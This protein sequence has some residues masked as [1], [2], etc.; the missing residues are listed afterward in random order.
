MMD[1]KSNNKNTYMEPNVCSHRLQVTGTHRVQ[2]E[3]FTYDY[4][5]ISDASS[6]TIA[7]PL[8]LTKYMNRNGGK[9]E[10]NLVPHL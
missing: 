2:Y 10:F 9:F 8:I 7:F 5:V 1:T 4:T 3:S 6:Q